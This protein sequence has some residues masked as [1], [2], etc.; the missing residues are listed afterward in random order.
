MIPKDGVVTGNSLVTV[1]VTTPDG[2][3]LTK[4]A[5]IAIV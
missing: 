3:Q 1:L 2:K 4:T 5:S